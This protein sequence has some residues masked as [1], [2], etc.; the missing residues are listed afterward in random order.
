MNFHPTGPFGPIPCF[1]ADPA[2][3]SEPPPVVLVLQE[4]FG[5]NPYIRGVCAELAGAGFTAVAIDLFHDH[6]PG[7][8]VGYDPAG[9]TAGRAQIAT[10]DLGRLHAEL[11]SLVH[12]L[13]TDIAEGGR[14]AVLGF[15]YGGLLAWETHGLHGT[16][17]AVAY[18]GRAHSPS[19]GGVPP[20]ER[21]STMKG[22]ILAHF[23]SNDASIPADAVGACAAALVKGAA[24][25]TIEVW[26]RTQH[27]FHCWDRGAFD[28]F[29]A[30]RSWAATLAF[31]RAN[32][33]GS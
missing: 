18:Y 31:F 26:P 21:T 9:V 6:T 10:L 29:A 33:K 11:E 1:R 23:A 25:G 13:R 28:P 4:I 15:C 12:T 32:L 30:S 8:E 7:F 19:L 24:R 5:V 2:L 3:A 27:G 17:A 16:D 20:I 22:P 14:V